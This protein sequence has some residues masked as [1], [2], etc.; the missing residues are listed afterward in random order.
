[1]GRPKGS[2]NKKS[3]APGTE[4]TAEKWDAAAATANGEPR[5]ARIPLDH[6]EEQVRTDIELPTP[7]SA[8]GIA[9]A[10]RKAA[11]AQQRV[12]QRLQKIANLKTQIAELKDE[13]GDIEKENERAKHLREVGTG[14]SWG[15]VPCIEVRLYRTNT[16]SIFRVDPATG[17]RG[18]HV[19]DRAMS[20]EEREKATFDVRTE[21]RLELLP[22]VGDAVH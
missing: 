5:Q 8:D 21:E 12:E 3:G 22:D 14:S 13:I 20:P 6:D 19:R 11:E 2:K 17:E 10:A 7:L 9:F 18:E 1:M 4:G 16:V 15:L